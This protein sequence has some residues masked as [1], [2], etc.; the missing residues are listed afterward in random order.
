VGLSP[1]KNFIQRMN[2]ALQA[3]DRVLAVLSAAYFASQYAADEWTA[4]LV[5]DRGQPDRLLPVRVAPCTLPRCSLTGSTSTWLAWR[6]PRRR[7]G[8]VPG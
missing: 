5:R 6:R 7:R 8:C 3:A 2:Q 1:G 4:A